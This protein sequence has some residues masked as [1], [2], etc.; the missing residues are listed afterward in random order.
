MVWNASAVVEGQSFSFSGGGYVGAGGFAGQT[1]SILPPEVVTSKLINE[2][3]ESGA[4]Q[5]ATPNLMTGVAEQESVYTAAIGAPISGQ[6]SA[7]LLY[8]QAMAAW[9]TE[10]PGGISTGLMQVNVGM[11]DAFGWKTNVAD[12]VNLF[13]GQKLHFATVVENNIIAAHVGLSPLTGSQLEDMALGEYGPGAFGYNTAKS[14]Y[15]ASCVNGVVSGKNC[16]GGF[17]VWVMNSSGNP[18]AIA[19]IMSVRSKLQS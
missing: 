5:R 18:T 14:V 6:F 17:W 3:T 8:G 15:V 7:E 16:Q 12:G 10:S 13:T 11:A 19:Y 2:Y 1:N 4:I 9:P